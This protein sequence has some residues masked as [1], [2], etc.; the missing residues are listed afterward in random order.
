MLLI[1]F[2]YYKDSP[3]VVGRQSDGKI[4]HASQT[5][6]GFIHRSIQTGHWA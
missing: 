4:V 3:L 6:S 1:L 2:I 5:E